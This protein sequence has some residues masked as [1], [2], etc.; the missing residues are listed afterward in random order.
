[1]VGT[2]K[3]TKIPLFLNFLFNLE[4]CKLKKLKNIHIHIKLSDYSSSFYNY[5]RLKKY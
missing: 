5:G 2:I 3:K 1:M 4:I